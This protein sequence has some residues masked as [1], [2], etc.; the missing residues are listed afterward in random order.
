[1]VPNRHQHSE[2]RSRL[3]LAHP[4]ELANRFGKQILG[5]AAQQRRKQLRQ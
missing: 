1:M 3:G 4:R 2:Q 5:S